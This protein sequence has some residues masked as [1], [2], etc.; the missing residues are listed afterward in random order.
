MIYKGE[1]YEPCELEFLEQNY[2]KMSYEELAGKLKRTT[3]GV[4]K[5]AE[6]MGL[7]KNDSP[8]RPRSRELKTKWYSKKVIN[9]HQ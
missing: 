6:K 2:D 9:K 5:Q 3:D 8:N 7:A 4:K 1:P